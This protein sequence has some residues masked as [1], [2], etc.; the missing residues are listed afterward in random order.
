M[1][2]MNE[3]LENNVT[4]RLDYKVAAVDLFY[5]KITSTS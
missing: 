3:I 2:T 5:Q 1:V 4:A